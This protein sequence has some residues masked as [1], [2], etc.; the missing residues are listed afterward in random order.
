MNSLARFTLGKILPALPF[1]S[2]LLFINMATPGSIHHD[3]QPRSGY[4]FWAKSNHPSNQASE[5]SSL[6]IVALVIY[7]ISNEK[8]NSVPT[9]K[10]SIYVDN[11]SSCLQID[12][13][14]YSTTVPDFTRAVLLAPLSFTAL[15][16]I[17]FTNS[18][19]SWWRNR[20][21]C[22]LDR[23]HDWCI[24]CRG[25]RRGRTRRPTSWSGSRFL[26]SIRGCWSSFFSGS[27]RG[28]KSSFFVICFRGSWSSFLGRVAGG[29]RCTFLGI[30]FGGSWSGFF[31]RTTS[32]GWCSV[33]VI[34]FT[35]FW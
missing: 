8:G 10:T 27:T 34:I 1:V 21:I 23:C 2:A 29:S 28:S 16:V 32:R 22:F 31:G 7:E 9:N 35:R 17:V 15:V 12:S 3:M 5:R 4:C 25:F 30:M 14:K 20:S 24:G 19:Y 6:I 11:F 13:L 18:I 33:Q 26:I